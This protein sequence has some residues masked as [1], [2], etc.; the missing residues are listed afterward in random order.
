MDE[1]SHE[2]LHQRWSGQWNREQHAQLLDKLRNE[3]ARTVVF[4]VVFAGEQATDSESSNRLAVATT[5]LAT[6]MG[7]HGRVVI[8]SHARNAEGLDQVASSQMSVETPEES[9]A[10]A[11]AGVGV[12]EVFED[13]DTTVR[14]LLTEFLQ[15]AGPAIPTLDLQAARLENRDPTAHEP[16]DW[17]LN[18]YGPPGTIEAESYYRALD[19]LPKGYFSNKV[20]VIG[21]FY[22]IELSGA[23]V[24]TFRSPFRTG[25]ARFPGVEIHA[26]ILQNLLLGEWLR[27]PPPLVQLLLFV[28]LGALAGGLLPRLKPL[29]ASAA[30]LGLIVV[31]IFA[32][33]QLQ[34]KARI[35]LPWMIPAFVQIPVALAWAILWHTLK[36][37]MDNQFLERSLSL[38]LSPQAVQAMLR[39]PELLR[40]GGAQQRVSIL[41]SDITNF[42]KISSRMDAEDLLGLLNQYYEQAIA[43]IH[44]TDGTVINL[45][46][47]AIFAVWNAPQDQP[48]HQERA[49]Q[50]ALS[51]HAKVVSFNQRLDGPPLKTRLGLHCGDA[52]VG[53]MGSSTHFDYTA[54]GQAVN[55]AFR[56]EGLNK[57]IGTSILASR[58]FLKGVHEQVAS[59]MLGHF[60]FKGFDSVVEVHEI[61]GP[62]RTSNSEEPWQTAFA[63]GV[64]H[65]HRSDFSL[66]EKAFRETIGL[67]PDDGPSLFLLQESLKFQSA[68]PHADWAGEIDMTEK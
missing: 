7:K 48:D 50:T 26:T 25:P 8:A 10:R 31:V 63:Q 37:Y 51:L 28:V 57:Q 13:T 66:A 46:G 18:Y 67:H 19:G 62:A 47:D 29:T 44:E 22:P 56:L 68:K 64:H 49:L 61:L 23:R 36:A 5:N 60:R 16:G 40:P 34:W 33:F 1:A 53:N 9:L 65:F 32:A 21:E 17:W 6:A 55:L 45:V 14:N 4:D 39:Q 42:S 38:Y 3:G 27:S 20:V 11:A 52:C 35:W 15:R 12:P 2:E 54:I 43:C 24:D 41:A 30:A 59:R 58:D